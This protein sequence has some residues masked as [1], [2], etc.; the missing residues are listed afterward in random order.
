MLRCEHSG[1]S[2]PPFRFVHFA[3]AAP[4][5][6]GDREAI[7][8]CSL[9]ALVEALPVGICVIGDAAYQPTEHMVPVY[10]GADKLL[11]KYDNFNFF[12]SQCRIRVEMAFGM[13]QGKW[14]I[15]QRPLSCS[16]ANMLWLSQATARL[17]NYCINER[18]A[19]DKSSFDP[20]TS[21]PHYIPSVPHNA[22]GDPVRLQHAFEG[23]NE[24]QSF[25]HEWMAARVSRKQL[26][27]PGNSDNG[28]TTSSKK[29]SFET[30]GVL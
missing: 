2:R 4:G 1:N 11:P 3:F 18:L 8:Q 23:A 29:R 12:A 14:G 16:M 27:R 24:G 13:W 15:L 28:G 5:V 17:H 25:L 9:Y 22:D 19:E 10:Q 7:K 6:T 26:Q 20:D 30:T 21:V